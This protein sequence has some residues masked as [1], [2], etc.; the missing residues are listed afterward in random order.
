MKTPAEVVQAAFDAINLEDWGPLAELCDPVSLRL[1]K[2]ERLDQATTTFRRFSTAADDAFE[3]DLEEIEGD[4]DCGFVDTEECLSREL[5]NV[6]TLEELREM[7][8]ARVLTSSIGMIDASPA[9][10]PPT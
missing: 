2:E 3:T 5:F 6:R 1:F 10:C 7:D 4:Y 8:P 9:G